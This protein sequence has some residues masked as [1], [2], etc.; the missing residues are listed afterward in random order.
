MSDQA[1]QALVAG[2]VQAFEALLNALASSQNEQRA[3][4]EAALTELRKYPDACASQLV[5]S[6]RSSPDL[7]SRALCAVLLRKVRRLGGYGQTAPGR[8]PPSWR[9]FSRPNRRRLL[10]SRLRWRPRHP[11]GFT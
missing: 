1:V 7:Q 3:A 8:L 5:R 6:L 11:L 2:D 4:A 9:Q 10:G